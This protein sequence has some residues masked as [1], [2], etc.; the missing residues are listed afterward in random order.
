MKNKT[1][2]ISRN[3]GEI[4]LVEEFN[5]NYNGG[6]F[7]KKKA[8]EES[9]YLDIHSLQEKTNTSFRIEK[10]FE[11]EKDA[12]NYLKKFIKENPISEAV[13]KKITVKELIH[14]V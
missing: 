2:K 5:H 9:F 8:I 14:Y 4:G 13:I 12:E 6:S 10:Y 3:K 11:T 1:I 7:T